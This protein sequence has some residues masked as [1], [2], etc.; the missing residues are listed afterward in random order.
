VLFGRSYSNLFVAPATYS[1][2]Y[3][4]NRMYP[5]NGLLQ[6]D[7]WDT[8]RKRQKVADAIWVAEAEP[9][10]IFNAEAMTKVERGAFAR[11]ACRRAGWTNPP[12]GPDNRKL[13]MCTSVVRVETGNLRMP[14]YRMTFGAYLYASEDAG[15]T[16]LMKPNQ[17]PKKPANRPT[18][19]F[20]GMA[21][22]WYD[23]D[24]ITGRESY[25]DVLEVQ[26]IKYNELDLENQEWPT[27]TF[28]ATVQAAVI[29]P[30]AI[31]V[32]GQFSVR[33]RTV[34]KAGKSDW[35]D[36]VPFVSPP[37]AP[38]ERLSTATFYM[39]DG[40][41]PIAANDLSVLVP[42]NQHCKITGWALILEEFE[43]NVQLDVQ[44]CT[45][46]QRRTEGDAAFTSITAAGEKLFVQ[47]TPSMIHD[48]KYNEGYD[49]TDWLAPAHN[50]Y[51]GDWLR[52]KVL[53][54]E[55]EALYLCAV[56]MLQPLA[57]PFTQIG[58]ASGGQIGMAA[59]VDDDGEALVDDDFQQL[60]DSYT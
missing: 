22:R 53:S 37:Q 42:I 41:E 20:D 4:G 48:G 54:A 6:S 15:R 47:A 36:P 46:Y 23:E 32:G 27:Y 44:F 58:Q 49:I 52:L 29:P 56:L 60:T 7:H 13:L 26:I 50:L 5:A 11:I 31:P 34:G 55:T 1:E 59:T 25:G 19:T 35:S 24:I 14:R 40:A 3:G 45:A 38:S 8:Y 28:N 33:H 21:L 18:P 51:A 17:N 2:L 9:K 39:G 43:G 10:I 57:T 16:H 30:D 12:G